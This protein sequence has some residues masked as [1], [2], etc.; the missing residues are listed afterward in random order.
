M[1]IIFGRR[2][3]LEVSKTVAAAKT[4]TNVSKAASAV[5]TS[6]AH[7]FLVGDVLLFT[8]TGPTQLDGIA[9]IVTA[10]DANTFTLGG[11]NST[12]FGD[13][14][15]A[16]AAKVTAWDAFTTLT[17]IDVTQDAPE[18]QEIRT[19]HD[20]ESNRFATAAGALNGTISGY[21][22][23]QSVAMQNV[24]QASMDL[25]TRVFRGTAETGEIVVFNADVSGGAG[26]NL[27][28]GAAG[29][30]SFAVAI[31]RRLVK[32]LS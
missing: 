16:T 25:A 8:A 26:F 29:T 15:A 11:V 4:L 19:L 24:E 14:V 1:A 20:S 7:G 21:L 27:A 5:C 3:K 10:A 28:A 13:F 31:K 17:T 6:T 32:K 9:A 22:D 23:W 2:V 12:A 18:L 30:S